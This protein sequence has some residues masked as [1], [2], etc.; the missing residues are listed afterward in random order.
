M[1]LLRIAIALCAGCAALLTPELNA[2]A[3]EPSE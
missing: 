3:L 1:S 2:A